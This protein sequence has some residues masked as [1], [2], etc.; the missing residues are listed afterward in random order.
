MSDMSFSESGQTLGFLLRSLY[1]ALQVRVYGELAASGFPDIRV[2]HSVVFRHIARTGSRVSDLAEKA[3]MTKQSMAYLV[4]ILA[5]GGYVTI[6]SDPADG[7]AKTVRL[8][9][10]GR[11]VAQTLVQLSRNVEAEFARL[12][13]SDE[14]AMLRQ[15]LDDLVRALERAERSLTP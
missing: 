14:M 4:E 11:N 10:R 5:E 9:A 12:I 3:R 15:L 2:A 13:G 6:R 8:T 7:R 1:D